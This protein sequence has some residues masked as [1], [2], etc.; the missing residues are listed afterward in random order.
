MTVSVPFQANTG[1]H[2]QQ[3]DALKHGFDGFDTEKAGVISP[4]QM[5]VI[6]KMMGNAVQVKHNDDKLLKVCSSVHMIIY[7][8]MH[9]TRDNGLGCLDVC[10]LHVRQWPWA[11]LFG[12]ENGRNWLN[13]AERWDFKKFTD[14]AANWCEARVWGWVGSC[15][16]VAF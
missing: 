5:Q 16:F 4:N 7:T 2:M 1:L 12:A 11:V 10:A 14:K 8:G 6:F 15:Q 13:V 9:L 3:I